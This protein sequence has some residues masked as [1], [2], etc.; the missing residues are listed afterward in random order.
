MT[1]RHPLARD[2][3]NNNLHVIVGV[4]LL[5]ALALS[6]RW[7][8]G[9]RTEVPG[10]SF[11]PNGVTAATGSYTPYASSPLPTV[12]GPVPVIQTP[13]P[14]L[15]VPPLPPQLRPPAPIIPATTTA[16]LPPFW[17]ATIPLPPVNAILA[18]P[19]GK[20]W[21]ATEGGLAQRNAEDGTWTLLRQSEGRFPAPQADALAHDGKSLWVGSSVGLF[22][23]EDGRSFRSYGKSDGLISDIIWSLVWDGQVLWVGTQAGVSFLT[24]PDGRFQS[25]DKKITNGGL[26]DIWIGAMLRRDN[27]L[28]CG[29]DDGLSIWDTRIPAA[30]PKGWTTLDMFTTNLAHNWILA[31]TL[32]E[33]EIWVGTP[34]GI[35]RLDTPIEEVFKSGGNARWTVFNKSQGLPGDRV[36]ALAELKGALWLGSSGGLT[37]YSNKAFRTL[38]MTE[39]LMASDVRALAVA[40]ETLW[41]GTGA[42]IQA[43][44]PALVNF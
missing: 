5:I 22:R 43:L 14:A 26:A 39:G 41:V 7:A 28:C 33:R 3:K 24:T 38:R 12:A 2:P 1:H 11:A 35:C 42:G 44:D 25:M 17:T 16:T 31:L 9:S 19:D 34:L 4:I 18:A 6:I 30:D 23:T 32:F 20:L 21:A 10:F 40:S 36:N 37:R 29:N 15:P 13:I 27:Y 8:R